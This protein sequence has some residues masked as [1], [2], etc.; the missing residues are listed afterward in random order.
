MVSFT[1]IVFLGALHGGVPG[2]LGPAAPV[3][4]DPPHRRQLANR[5]LA[6][7]VILLVLVLIYVAQKLFHLEQWAN[8]LTIV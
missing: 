2:A 1:G 5:L 7:L 8:D 6:A 3:L 4:Q